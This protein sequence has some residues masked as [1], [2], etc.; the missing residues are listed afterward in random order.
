MK[1]ITLRLPQC[2]TCGSHAVRSYGTRMV[3]VEILRYYRCECGE[4]F[5]AI[6]EN[7]RPVDFLPRVGNTPRRESVESGQ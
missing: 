2:P 7:P 6:I 3:S 4:Q 5:Q 1:T